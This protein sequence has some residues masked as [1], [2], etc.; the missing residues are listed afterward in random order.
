MRIHGK[1]SWKNTVF[2]IARTFLI[3]FSAVT[4]LYVLIIVFSL[5]YI[6]GF[7]EGY[8]EMISYY[9]SI[10][11]GRLAQEDK[12]TPV[13]T[14]VIVKEVPFSR[15]EKSLISTVGWGGP[16]LWVAVNAKRQ[17]YGVN[18]LNQADELCTIASVRLNE[19]LSLGRLDGHEG[20][21]NLTDRRPDFK[22]IF[23]KYSTVA[24]F[25]LAGAKT[26]DEAVSLWEN[27]LAHRKL[28]T[29]G[30]YVWGCIYAQNSFAVAIAAY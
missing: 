1:V 12:I 7:K 14:Q 2:I 5:G 4:F 21:S 13:P 30:E 11:D 22:W 17:E 29:G 16:D 20:F 19:L 23:D 25:L 9:E 15:E 8:L 18:H 24:E 10:P 28:L 6:T 27:T 26:A 3:S